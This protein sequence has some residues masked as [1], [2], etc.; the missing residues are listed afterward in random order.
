[1]FNRAFPKA[2]RMEA[3]LIESLAFIIIIISSS[4]SSNIPYS[5]LS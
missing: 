4:S 2:I 3:N 1:M 5:S